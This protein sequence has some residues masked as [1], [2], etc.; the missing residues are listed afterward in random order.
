MSDTPLPRDQFP[1]AERYVYLNHAGV[2]PLSAVAVDAM[3]VAA[4]AFRDDGGLVYERY[5][6]LMEQTRAAS[7]ALMGVPLADVAFV[8]NTTEGIALAASGIDWKPDD[9]VIV[10]NYEFPSNVYPWIALRDR[11]VRVDAIE[12]AG[13]RREL[14]IELFAEA[15]QQAPTRVVAVSWVQFGYGWRTDLAELGVLCR[16]HNALLCVD[17]IQ[18]LGVLPA[19]FEEWGVDVASADAHKWLLGPH[20]IGIAAV[21]P[22]AREQLRP[23]QPGWASVP[24]REEWDNLELVFDETARR[25][26]GGSPNVITTVGMGASIDLLLDAG[27]EAI[28]HHVDGLCQRLAEGLTGLGAEL[29]SVHDS[30]NRSAIVSFTL[31]NRETDRLVD[32][33]EAR[34]ILARARAGAVRLAP[35]GYNTDDEIDTTL[36]AIAKLA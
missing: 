28:W 4:A 22:R 20:G 33:L 12:P 35:H 10:P 11:G 25:Y 24:Y 9:R 21:S 2:G 16:E 36:A 15:L 23:Q 18:G 30:E 32:A 6:E 19:R 31:P 29:K 1:V 8:K 14:R 27:A 17:A 3:A 7:A 26:E 34:G 13:P 5:D